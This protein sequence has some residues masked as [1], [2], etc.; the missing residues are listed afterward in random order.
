MSSFNTVNT[1]INDSNTRTGTD[2][3]VKYVYTQENMHYFYYLVAL[4]LV[5]N[6]LILYFTLFFRVFKTN[7]VLSVCNFDVFYNS[8]SELT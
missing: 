6:L 1:R 3:R 8:E 7:H 4:R 5:S 2:T